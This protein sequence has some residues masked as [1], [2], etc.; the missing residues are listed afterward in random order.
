[1]NTAKYLPPEYYVSYFNKFTDKFPAILPLLKLNLPTLQPFVEQD[2][3]AIVSKGSLHSSK[4]IK[5]TT[6]HHHYDTWRQ[7]VASDTNTETVSDLYSPKEN[8]G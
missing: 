1:M 8:L 2:Y 5:R 6:G 4:G 3:T 7:I